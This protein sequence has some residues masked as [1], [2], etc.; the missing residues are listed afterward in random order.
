MVPASLS[1]VEP[2]PTRWKYKNDLRLENR[3]PTDSRGRSSVYNVFIFIYRDVFNSIVF[4]CIFFLNDVVTEN[5]FFFS[6]F[7]MNL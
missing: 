6:F 1:S 4:F 3:S 7:S 5:C 2:S